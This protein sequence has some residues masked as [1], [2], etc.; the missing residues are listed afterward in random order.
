MG[1]GWGRSKSSSS[2]G[3]NRTAPRSKCQREEECLYR[4]RGKFEHSSRKTQ[5]KKREK[6]RLCD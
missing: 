5:T 3:K 4:A 6:D 1:M 2:K